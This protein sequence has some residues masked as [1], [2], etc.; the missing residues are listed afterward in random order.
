M[1]AKKQKIISDAAQESTKN[2]AEIR[3]FDALGLQWW[4]ESG[5]MAPLHRMN[6]ARLGYIKGQ[7]TTTFERPAR[8]LQDL[9]GLRIADIGCGGGLITEPL[10]R[11]GAQVTGIDAGEENIRIAG[12]HAEKQGLKIR[13]L[14]TTAESLAAK[15]ET[16][17]VVLALEIIEHVAN[18]ELF[19]KSCAALVRPGGMLILS[20]LNRTPKSFLLGIV[21]AE[22]ILRW[23]PA[24]T[25]DWKKFMKPGEIAMLL[26]KYGMATTDVSGL[27]FHPLTGN[28]A[29]SK[30]DMGVN[31]FL[32]AIRP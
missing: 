21:A 25:H 14:N 4:D 17:D 12:Q 29:I 1:V 6:P 7:I 2:A 26:E 23:L 3:R 15:G 18:P 28:F 8:P 5:P 27:V 11:L 31:Y 30:K 16:F 9:K 22:H 19:L 13:Y 24:G 10:C 32:T 20:T